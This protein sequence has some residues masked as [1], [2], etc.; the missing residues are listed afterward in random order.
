MRQHAFNRSIIEGAQLRPRYDREVG[1]FSLEQENPDVCYANSMPGAPVGQPGG[2]GG[3]PPQ[4]V[5]GHP[6]GVPQHQQP[7]QVPASAIVQPPSNVPAFDPA[8]AQRE[9]ALNQQLGE[10]RANRQRLE[11]ENAARAE[12]ERQVHLQTLPAEQRATAIVNDGQRQIDLAL[13]QAQEATRQARLA[14]QQAELERHTMRRVYQLQQQGVPFLEELVGGR[15]IA[16]IEASVQFAQDEYKRLQSRME[17]EFRRKYNLSEQG[18]PLSGGTSFGVPVGSLP[19]NPAFM[20]PG[21]PGQMPTPVNPQTVTEQPDQVGG[22]FGGGVEQAVRSG[23]W[24]QLRDHQM[25]QM[26]GTMGAGMPLGNQPRHLTQQVQAPQGYMPPPN[27]AMPPAPP[28]QYPP[29]GHPGQQPWQPP[30]AYAPVP[31][32]YQ[33]PRPPPPPQNMVQVWNGYAHE[34][35]PAGPPAPIPYGYPGGQTQQ[36]PT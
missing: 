14:Q 16:E 15:S 36:N 19:A 29:Y 23:A 20:P 2:F 26:R 30:P 35:R 33:P 18:L 6:Q 21:M 4:Q 10:E 13:A 5:Y 7:I 11:Q 12:R 1:L 17:A 8:A 27:Y 32:Q 24:G 25:A 31:A 9:A 28:P 22:V 3:I 34:W